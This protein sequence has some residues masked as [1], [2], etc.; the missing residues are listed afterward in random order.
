M[1]IPP[2][3]CFDRQ[4]GVTRWLKSAITLS[5][6]AWAVAA[7]PL[8]AAPVITE[9][10]A[11]N[12]TTI[13]DDDGDYSDWVEIHN[14]DA[15]AVS[16]AGWHL[17]D[18]ANNKT[19][20][21]FPAGV[22]IPANGYLLV[23]ASNKNRGTATTPL[24]TNWA[25]GA[26]GEYLGLIQPD[27]TTVVSEFAPAFPAQSTDTSYGVTQ[28]TAAGE[29][30][31]I[32]YFAT[33]TPGQRNGG[34]NTLIVLGDVSFSQPARTFVGSLTLELTGAGASQN[35]RY[36]ITAPT[37][38]GAS[39]PAPT[40]S[41]TIYNGPI[42]LS[43]SA[44]VKA[45]VFSADGALRGQVA[46]A[47][48][49]RVSDDV[50][51]FSSQLPII[52]LDNHGLGPMVKDDID[53]DGWL[54]VFAT[55]E[56]G[57]AALRDTAQL[58][59][60]MEFK[61]RGTSSAEFPKKGFN[62]ELKRTAGGDNPQPLLGMPASEDW[63]LVAPWLYDR[64]Y[65]R[66]AFAYA[67]SNRMGRWAPRTRFAEAFLNV[68]GGPVSSSDYHGIVI[69][70]D[71]VLFGESRINLTPVA[72]NATTEPGI[73]GA[74]ILQIDVPDADE[75]SFHTSRG[76]PN[77][78]ES[79]FLVSRPKAAD[80]PQAHRNYVQN[81]VQAMEDAI[82]GDWANNF[83]TRNYRNYIDPD[84][85]VD[86]HLLNIFLANADALL[87]SV[88]F[89]K[90]Q[91]GKLV[92]GPAWDF[93][94]SAGSTDW[95]TTRW[96]TWQTTLADVW[97]HGWWGP[98]FR[99]PEFMQAWVDRWQSLR[100][101]AFSTNQLAGL[102]SE[103]A[104]Q[105]G[106]EA[107]E[108]DAARWPENRS[109]AAGG[110]LAEVTHL[111]DWLTLRAEWMDAQFLAPPDFSFEGGRVTITPLPDTAIVYT[112]DG[113]DPR[114][115]GGVP[116]AGAVVSSEPVVLDDTVRFR[117]R[118]Y[119]P[120]QPY[121]VPGSPWSS[122]VE[123]S[124]LNGTARLINVSSRAYSGSGDNV[125]IA[126]VVVG[127]DG[128]ARFL[129]RAIGPTLTRYEVGGVLV[130][131]TI[132]VVDG[133]GQTIGQNVSWTDNPNTEELKTIMSQVGAFELPEGSTDAALVM[134]LTPGVYSFVVRGVGNSAG[135][136]LAEVYEVDG[137]GGRAINLSTRARVR[138]GEGLLIGGVAVKGD[139]PKKLLIRGVGPSLRR[140]D[141]ID[142]LVDPILTIYRG[143][144]VLASNDD[145]D[146]S[147]EL[148]D[149]MASAGA[150]PLDENST[151][152]ALVLVLPPGNYTAMVSGKNSTEG[153]ALVEV[154]ELE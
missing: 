11:S 94:R 154:Y 117:V 88:Y 125:L 79:A 95:R 113:S 29:A 131:P 98:L 84:S 19:K 71:R 144:D 59:T 91:G 22:S 139:N 148:I 53:R 9:F 93:D 142:R 100:R 152:A 2:T 114:A 138:A 38:A 96:D 75:F 64:A 42:T 136:A 39:A 65:I 33:P 101:G 47:H 130:N 10:M 32:G 147:Q 123:L 1:M 137:A 68:D 66:N 8:Q 132:Q 134:E 73:T 143:Q 63:A 14:P 25:L 102:V 120:S 48:Y 31:Q 43:E 108:R 76:T 116:A 118:S 26:G 17:T 20:W 23:W 80:L 16:L 107:A 7:T 40:A 61:V 121:T 72:A 36:T 21:T 111:Q 56:N 3:N 44:I 150:F 69:V 51:S 58:V 151:D 37:S 99:D 57:R 126:G 5:T 129:A 87:R 135:I 41:S 146:G 13:R 62:V 83:Q 103:L 35:I 106:P 105:I 50:A 90:D 122:A 109:E 28:P 149:A 15:V 145:W 67:L 124:D 77:F 141:V 86:Q 89:T 12:A 119:R 74:Y 85:W 104:S 24:H 30:S 45:A 133:S 97:N 127:G 140:F 70:T 78:P 27:G 153:I 18:S 52:I 49:V 54:H 81:H 128:P 55:G 115:A 46:T 112:L 34:A 6:A 82:Y 60:P 4:P 92:A 110:F